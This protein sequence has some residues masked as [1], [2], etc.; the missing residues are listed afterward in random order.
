MKPI[1]LTTIFALLASV[2]LTAPV[3]QPLYNCGTAIASSGR[4]DTSPAAESGLVA[5]FI[6]KDY[7]SLTKRLSPNR[8]ILPSI[9]IKLSSP[10]EHNECPLPSRAP[11]N[12]R[13]SFAENLPSALSDLHVPRQAEYTRF[14]KQAGGD[15]V[16]W[17]VC[18]SQASL[19]ATG[20]ETGSAEKDWSDLIVVGIVVLFL[21]AV[22][23]VESV[24]LALVA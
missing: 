24:E 3:P 6:S 15:T 13:S 19:R 10:T 14:K 17:S 4:L 1:D 23:I 7:R 12:L 16:E 20:C 18:F 11:V 21:I 8:P 2:A 9:L 5:S 22:L